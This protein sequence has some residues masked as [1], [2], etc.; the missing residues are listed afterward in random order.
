MEN[1]NTFQANMKICKILLK[2]NLL[3]LNIILNLSLILGINTQNKDKD[4]LITDMISY[5]KNQDIVNINNFQTILEENMPDNKNEQQIITNKNEINDS[6]S[7]DSSITSK[8]NNINLNNNIYK[9]KLT[10]NEMLENNNN[11]ILEKGNNDEFK[12]GN[13]SELE[14]DSEEIK[15]MKKK[16]KINLILSY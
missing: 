10:H 4:K 8:I 3:S 15:P 11:I 16:K 5:L 6:E 12:I 14:S 1:T 9:K 7:I 2:L 13:N